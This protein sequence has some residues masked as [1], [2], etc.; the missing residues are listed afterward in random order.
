M[1]KT[2][3]AIIAAVVVLV[4]GLVAYFSV[5]SLI[6]NS[7]ELDQSTFFQYIEDARGDTDETDGVIEDSRQIV[8]VHIDGFTIYGYTN[9]DARDYAYW[10]TLTMGQNSVPLNDKLAEWQESGAIQIV[11]A[12]D[13]NAGAEKGRRI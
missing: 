12:T 1:S 13:P 2:V 4:L 11:S 10:A 9:V 3:K 8:R 5:T 7:R 6:R